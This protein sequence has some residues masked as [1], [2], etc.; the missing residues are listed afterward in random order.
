M[1]NGL[2]FDA[3]YLNSAG[4]FDVSNTPSQG[5]S[6]IQGDMEKLVIDGTTRITSFEITGGNGAP[7]H[8]LK[9]FSAEEDDLQ[10]LPFG[11]H[12]DEDEDP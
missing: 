8:Y 3:T 11:S 5:I 2:E 4:T 1:N 6:N 7:F 12:E 10:D 9:S